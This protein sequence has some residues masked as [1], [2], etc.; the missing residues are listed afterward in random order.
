MRRA[1]NSG[2]G[3]F[4]PIFQEE[5]NTFRPIFFGYFIADRLLYNS[6]D[7]S[8]HTTKLVADFIRPTFTPPLR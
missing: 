5:G 3:Q 2:V 4:K 8:F 6:A 7:G 1:S